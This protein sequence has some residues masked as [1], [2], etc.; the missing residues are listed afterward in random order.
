MR[1]Q[2]V[3]VAE[4]AD[5]EATAEAVAETPD[6]GLPADAPEQ[7]PTSGSRPSSGRGDGA[8]ADAELTAES[9]QQD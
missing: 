9:A 5:A 2:A 7:T 1:S 4:S 6:A 3:E 8:A